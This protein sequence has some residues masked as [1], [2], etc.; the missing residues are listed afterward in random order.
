MNK[1][2]KLLKT[3]VIDTDLLRSATLALAYQGMI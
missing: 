2:Q 1:L 3:G